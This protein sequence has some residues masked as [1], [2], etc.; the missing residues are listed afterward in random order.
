MAGPLAGLIYSATELGA[1]LVVY[2]VFYIPGKL[3]LLTRQLLRKLLVLTRQPRDKLGH[4]FMHVMFEPDPSV[5]E[6]QP[7]SDH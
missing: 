4:T 1:S 5:P 3:I 6:R 2:L 7:L